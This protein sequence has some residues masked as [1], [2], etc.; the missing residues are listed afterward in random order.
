MK[1][2]PIMKHPPNTT[3]TVRVLGNIETRI[4][5]LELINLLFAIEDSLQLEQ[6][7]LRYKQ[8]KP[9]QI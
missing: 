5:Q 6:L 7:Y 9:L 2:D 1:T 8:E 3:Y 4:R